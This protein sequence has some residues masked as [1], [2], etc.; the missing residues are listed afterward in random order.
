MQVLPSHQAK[1]QYV[2]HNNPNLLIQPAKEETISVYPRVVLFHDII[3]DS[4]ME[5][6][7]RRVGN[8]VRFCYNFGDDKPRV[9]K[10]YQLD[11]VDVGKQIYDTK[12]NVRKQNQNLQ[13]GMYQIQSQKLRCMNRS[14]PSFSLVLL[15]DI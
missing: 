14:T 1:C 9:T 6:V 8:K 2:H 10:L 15:N 12:I 5:H 13:K 11:R 7:L 4:E 3:T